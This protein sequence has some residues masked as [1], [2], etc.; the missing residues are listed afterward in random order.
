MISE[1]WKKKVEKVHYCLL[2]KLILKNVNKDEQHNIAL[3]TF[4]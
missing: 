3:S 4:I 1:Y 2:E